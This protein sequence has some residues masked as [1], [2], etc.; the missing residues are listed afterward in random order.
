MWQIFY[1][2]G[3]RDWN[4]S[5]GKSG[6]LFKPDSSLTQRQS[7]LTGNQ[8]KLNLLL[9]S[10]I[11]DQLGLC[12]N[13]QIAENRQYNRSLA[14]TF[15]MCSHQEIALRGHKDGEESINRGNFVEILNLVNHDSVI[16]E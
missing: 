12:R 8:Y 13:K 5:T 2:G 10:T 9:K 1:S 3:F 4:L 15:L 11:S 14:R 16:M 6:V 7:M